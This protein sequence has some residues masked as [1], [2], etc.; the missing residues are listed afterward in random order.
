MGRYN[1][2]AVYVAFD[3][4][5]AVNVP[6]CSRGR[7][8]GDPEN[9]VE[10]YAYFRHLLVFSTD[11]R[12]ST[13]FWTQTISVSFTDIKYY[14]SCSFRHR[15][16]DMKQTRLFMHLSN[17]NGGSVTLWNVLVWKWDYFIIF[18]QG[19]KKL[20]NY[21]LVTS[22]KSKEISNKIGK[23]CAIS[24]ALLKNIAVNIY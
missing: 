3:T 14:K 24:E 6:S 22:C 21:I 4:V 13:I 2:V 23:K 11:I 20:F 9:E 18:H 7:L 15:F 12:T 10:V 1:S 16:F 17:R 8:K 19:K 5:D